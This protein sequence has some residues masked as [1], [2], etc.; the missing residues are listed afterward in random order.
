MS[1]SVSELSDAAAFVIDSILEDVFSE[2]MRQLKKWGVQHH[3]DL[4]GE[5]DIR[6]YIL[7]ADD[8]KER[9]GDQADGWDTILLEEVYE[10]LAESDPQLLRAEL[11]QSA[12]V[13]AA[14]IEDIDSREDRV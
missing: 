5:D 10:A 3:P 7:L 13:I 11:V 4:G 1:V 9:N 14:W 12:A 2:R 6:E 8:Y